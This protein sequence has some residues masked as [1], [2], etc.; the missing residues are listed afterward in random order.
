MLAIAAAIVFA[1]A[2]L[3]NATSTA[4]SAVF[5]PPSLLLVGLVCLALHLAGLGS[6]LSVPRRRRR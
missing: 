3:I 5:S 4:T 1:I 6:G 2:F